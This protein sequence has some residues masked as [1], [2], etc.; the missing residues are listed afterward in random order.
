MKRFVMGQIL[1]LLLVSWSAPAKTV[2][3][4][5]AQVNDDIITL[6]DLN[7]E[8]VEIRDQLKTQF[9]GEQLEQE[10]KK[11]EQ[12][13]LESLIQ[14]KLLIQKANE[15]GFSANVDVQVSAYIQKIMADNKIKDTEDFERALSQQGMTLPAFRERIRRQ[16]IINSLIQEFVGSRI[17]LLAPEIEKYYKDHA[18]DFSTPE[19]V[20]LSEIIIPIEGDASEAETKANEVRKRLSQGEPFATL[21]SQF[22][23]GISASKG[24]GIGSYVAA[25]LHPDIA[26]AIA[27]VKEGEI[28]PVMKTKEGLVIYRVDTRKTASVQPLEEVKKEIQERMWSQK[29]NP[30]LKRF[31]A[32]LKEDA[33]IQIFTETK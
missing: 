5:V 11:A 28:T 4:I 19:E 27:P 25:K 3:R 16:I 31:V 6:S 23:K 13:A 20:T 33:Y 12:G 26:K 8:L 10:I 7:R 29:F 32:Q 24:G 21:A 2:D 17:T 14:E 1:V 18:Q 9:T 22:S 30:E 15:L